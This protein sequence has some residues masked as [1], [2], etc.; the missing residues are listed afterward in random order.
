MSSFDEHL[1]FIEHLDNQIKQIMTDGKVVLHDIPRIVALFTDLLRIK[2][3]TQDTETALQL[4]YDYIMTHY[5]LFP[6]DLTE[7]AAFKEV[8]ALCV[9]LVLFQ[10]TKKVA[11]TEGKGIFQKIF[12]CFKTA[13]KDV[14]EEMTYEINVVEDNN[15]I[16]PAVQ[17]LPEVKKQLVNV[18]D[19]VKEQIVALLTDQVVVVTEQTAE[20]T[21]AVLDK[22]N[23]AAAAKE[24]IWDSVA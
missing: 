24:K 23:E 22:V 13:K 5:N 21:D 12:T 10:A 8:F 7:L 18:I 4:F 6:T 19:E 20:Q 15:N 9:K 17:K 16:L 14:V 1:D 3:S 11:A 2:P